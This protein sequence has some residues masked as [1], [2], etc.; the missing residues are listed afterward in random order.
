MAKE[1]NN[2]LGHS[3]NMSKKQLTE[4]EYQ[5]KLGMN[6]LQSKSFIEME[7]LNTKIKPSPK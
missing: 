5:K 7:Q 6:L 1:P 3:A 4:K 2:V